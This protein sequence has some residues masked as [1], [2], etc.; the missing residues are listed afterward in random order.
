[1]T[2]PKRTLL[3][4][5]PIYYV[6]DVPHV[7]HAYTTI[8]ADTLTRARRLAGHDVFFLT[9][10]D[11]HGQNIERI[12]REKG[13]SEQEHCDRISAAFRALWERYDIRYDR[14]I[15]TTEDVHKRGV[16]KLWERLRAAKTPDGREAVYLGKYSGWYCPRCEGFKDEEELRQ[17]GHVCPDHERPCE[18][19][20]EE[21]FF[22]RLS[23]YERWLR[24]T[25]ETDRL[26]IRPESRKNEILG[27]IKQG[28][29]DFSVSRARVKWGI[30]VP[31]QPDHV[32]YVWVDAL[33][34]YVTALD[35][36]DDGEAYR[37]Y[38]AGG[39][40][41]LHLLGKDII[42]FHCLYWPAILHAAGLL[43]PNREFAQ[44]FITR[45]GRKLSKTTG[46]VIDPVALVERLG[47]DAARY[48]LLR[49]APYGAD[50]DFTE[51]AFVTR[52]NADLANDLGNLVSRALTMAARYGDGKVPPWGEAT[53]APATDFT[54]TFAATAC[55]ADGLAAK[56]LRR[57]EDIDFSGALTEIWSF[58][59][60]FNQAIVQVEPWSLAKDPARRAEL[61]AFLYRLVEGVRLVAV[62][63]SPVIP[64]AASRIFGMLGLGEREPGPGRPRLGPARARGAARQ[65]C[66]PLPPRGPDE[67][68]GDASVRNQSR[69]SEAG[70]RPGVARGD[71]RAG[72]G[73]RCPGPGGR[74]RPH[75]HQRVREDR[76]AGG[77][78]HRGGEGERLEEAREA[79]GRPRDRDAAGRGRDRRVLRARGSR[80]EDRRPRGEPEAG[81][82]HGRRVE[83]DG[84]RRVDLW[85]GH[86]V[87][88]RRRGGAGHEGE[89]NR[90]LLLV[91]PGLALAALGIGCPGQP[92]AVVYDLAARVPVAETWAAAD[93]LRFG[94]PAAEPRLTDGFHRESG[95]AEEPFLW[96]KGEAEVAFQWEAVL[97]RVAILD[98]APF[99]GVKEQSVEVRL[100][101]T[102]V[103][104]FVLNDVRHRYRI[105]LPAAAQKP[106]DNRLRFVFAETASPADSDPKS[107]DKRQLAAAFYTL[108]TGSASDASLEDLLGRDAPRP[109][110]VNA[111]KGV[112]AVVL[113]GPAVV[114]FAL[115]LPPS[116]ELR[117]TPELLPGARAA[118][119]RASFRVTVERPGGG[120]REAW[121]RVIDARATPAGEQ[122]VSLPGRA[123]DIVRVGLAVGEAGSPRFAWGRFVA[124]R[125][126]GRGGSDPLQPLPVS[127]ADDARAASPAQGARRDERPARHP[128]RR[129]CAVL[130]GVRLPPADDAGDRPHRPGRRR[131]RARVHAR[132]LHPRSDVVGLDLPVPRP[133]PQRGLV[134]GPSPQGPPHPRRGAGGAGRPHRGLRRELRGRPPLR[135]R[136]W[137]R[138]V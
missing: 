85:Q 29:K 35:Y 70:A 60:Q 138:R 4:T 54:A 41:R 86:P 26:L 1:M 103:E 34:N 62:L 77:E 47:P 132:R 68:E 114:R 28:L 14:F 48:F 98:A 52:Y 97:P 136:P 53:G 66:A 63:A 73:A 115:K 69:R 56:V 3:L 11:E 32:L 104:R 121:S 49:E 76:A 33:S 107:L 133:A 130:R 5:T 106:G 21:N 80:R 127:P 15:R 10:T 126:L 42:R 83:R 95:G 57:Y 24:E 78:G 87:H 27:V 74:R 94:T 64:R 137:L 89:V 38:W 118:A 39:D 101:G 2:S 67:R 46:N 25:I 7:G 100:N 135:I 50:W 102:P 88:V 61:D 19:T 92:K 81:H 17:P 23:A 134:L 75:R 129:P 44:G 99:R 131:V 91:G 120:E 96:S 124:P 72:P 116:A 109:F 6:N 9:G 51:Q 82:A 37:K 125:V 117:F 110:A 90:R 59:G 93:V 108:V 111:E 8:A 45:D 128:G 20:E 40:E 84:S 65:G 119:G 113:L 13:I 22:F 12:A 122:S 55:A 18:W 58:V 30:P 31:G 71:R 105:G 123:G 112:P 16:L 43:P 79:P 36:A